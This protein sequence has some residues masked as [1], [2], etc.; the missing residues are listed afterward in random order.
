[1]LRI[2]QFDSVFIRHGCCNIAD[3]NLWLRLSGRSFAVLSR[4]STNWDSG[5]VLALWLFGGTDRRYFLQRPGRSL[6]RVEQIDCDSAVS[7]SG[8]M[9]LSRMAQAR[10]AL[11]VTHLLL[12]SYTLL[13]LLRL[14][15]LLMLDLICLSCLLMRAPRFLG[16]ML[17]VVCSAIAILTDAFRL[18]HC[19]ETLFLS[20][21]SC[22]LSLLLTT[23]LILRI[24]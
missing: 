3:S 14:Y 17:M 8:L 6:M 5:H 4:A 22:H 2:F 15:G 16:M 13:T 10:T 1:M 21:A 23:I 19:S 18:N 24:P 11:L 20:R 12:T 9:L 7:C